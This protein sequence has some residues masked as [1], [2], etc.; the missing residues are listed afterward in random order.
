[1]ECTSE[2][3]R[4]VA[5]PA[6]SVAQNRAFLFWQFAGPNGESPPATVLYR[7]RREALA[8][9]SQ[10]LFPG[11]HPTVEL[12]VL[13]GLEDFSIDWSRRERQACKGIYIYNNIV[14]Q[15]VQL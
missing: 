13:H 4:M 12:R 14:V 6:G 15:F 3:P 8:D 11:C 2:T 10:R 1:M 5:K 7:W 9:E